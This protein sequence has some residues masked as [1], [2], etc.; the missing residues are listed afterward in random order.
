MNTSLKIPYALLGGTIVHIDQV[1][2]GI[3]CNCVCPI[4]KKPL[5]ARKGPK[6]THHFAHAISKGCSGGP[7]TVLHLLAKQIIESADNITSPSPN[8]KTI[9]IN[10][11]KLE[12]SFGTV[13]PDI[14][15]NNE[16]EEFTFIEIAVTH[17]CEDEKIKK[18][19]ELGIQAFEIQ[20]PISAINLNHDEL[21]DRIINQKEWKK[22]LY[23]RESEALKDPSS[24]N[25][26][27]PEKHEIKRPPPLIPSWSK[28]YKNNYELQKLARAVLGG[29]ATWHTIEEKSVLYD[30]IEQSIVEEREQNIAQSKREQEKKNRKD[31]YLKKSRGY[32]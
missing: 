3:A 8:S 20:L 24:P 31:E 5:V 18:L 21:K 17:K 29:K 22:W 7:E 16:S 28:Y 25:I 23:K 30:A 1:S 14:T 13:K 2:R 27:I 19:Q 12:K 26:H 10:S 15:I 6:T 32:S 4:C 9:H 11:V